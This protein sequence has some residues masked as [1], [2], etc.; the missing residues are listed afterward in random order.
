MHNH[1]MRSTHLSDEVACENK[2]DAHCVGVLE[3]QAACD[4]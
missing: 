1:A 2:N 3:G 4:G